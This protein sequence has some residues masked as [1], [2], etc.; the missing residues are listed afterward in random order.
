MDRRYHIAA[1]RETHLLVSDPQSAYGVCA[2]VAIRCREEAFKDL[3][4]VLLSVLVVLVPEISTIA[5]VVVVIKEVYIVMLIIEEC[6][7]LRTVAM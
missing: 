4:Y 5:V 6:A 7:Q 2:R 1:L 3:E